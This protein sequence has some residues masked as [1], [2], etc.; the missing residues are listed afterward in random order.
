MMMTMY[1]LHYTS[2]P[3]FLTSSADNSRTTDVKMVIMWTVL[4]AV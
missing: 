1:S 2:S 4:T 3:L